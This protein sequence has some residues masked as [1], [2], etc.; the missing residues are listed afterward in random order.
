[1]ANVGVKTKYEK[2]YQAKRH[3]H[4]AQIRAAMQGILEQNALPYE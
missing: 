3:H 4:H 2:V 1:M